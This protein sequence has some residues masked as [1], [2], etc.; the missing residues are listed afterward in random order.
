[1]TRS[2][3]YASLLVLT[4]LLLIPSCFAASPQ[5]PKAPGKGIE[6]IVIVRHAEK[7]KAGLGQLSVTGLKRSLLLP[8]FFAKNF[9]RADYIFAP[10]P[11][12]KHFENHGDKQYHYY[13]RPLATIEPTAITLGLPVNV[14]I[15]LNDHN[16]LVE[17]LLQS[18]Y[19]SSTIY[20]AWEHSQIV[21]I[22]KEIMTRFGSDAKVPDWKNSNFNMYFVFTIDWNKK[23]NQ[24]TF[25]VGDEGFHD[26]DKQAVHPAYL[27]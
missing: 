25:K 7:P 20:V 9:P 11:A 12:V 17:A 3:R 15:G 5:Q 8:E 10:N 13:I 19:H 26:L 21:K 6:T 24:L 14:G 27:N 4:S 1:M 18:K 16:K 2:L 22:A 23:E